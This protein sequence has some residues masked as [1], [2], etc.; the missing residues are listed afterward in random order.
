MRDL[1]LKIVRH[2]FEGKKD[3]AGEHYIN[4]LKRVEDRLKSKNEE[5]K[6]IA[7]LH[8]LLEDCPEWNE[9][10]LR[11]FFPKLVVEAVVILTKV[12]DEDYQDYITRVSESG[13]ATIVKIADLQDNMDVTR[14]KKLEDRDIKRLQK[15]IKAYQFLTK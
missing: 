14:L 7:L 3:L 2:A 9:D 11:C 1:A 10:V 8:D 6:T 4:H 15:Y 12:K 5:I 13:W